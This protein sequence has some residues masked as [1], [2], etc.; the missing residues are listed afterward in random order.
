MWQ[1]THVVKTWIA[2]GDGCEAHLDRLA[3]LSVL[4]QPIE[5]RRVREPLSDELPRPRHLAEGL[6]ARRA[7]AV[8]EH[9]VRPRMDTSAQANPHESPPQKT[10]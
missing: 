5:L 8:L 10:W 3:E 9:L 1:S 6:A 4:R 7:V 2:V